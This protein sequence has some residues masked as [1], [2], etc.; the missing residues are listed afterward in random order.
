MLNTGSGGVP[1]ILFLIIL[2]QAASKYFSGWKDDI[3]HVF[4][5]RI[6]VGPALA[7]S[8]LHSGQVA[9][10][11]KNSRQRRGGKCTP[12]LFGG[13]S[14]RAFW[15][16]CR[17]SRTVS[18]LSDLQVSSLVP[19]DGGHSKTSKAK[20]IISASRLHYQLPVFPRRSGPIM[21]YSPSHDA[22]LFAPPP[23]IFGARKRKRFRR[24]FLLLKR[25]FT[26]YFS[27]CSVYHHAGKLSDAFRAQF[28]PSES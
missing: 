18:S 6:G 22:P 25:T 7:S 12:R 14:S 11:A 9:A 5:I 4:W 3:G 19:N 16:D 15:V 28:F 21:R 24:Q 13:N 20:S 23:S 2:V 27:R 1:N 8:E 10:V 26:S 17:R